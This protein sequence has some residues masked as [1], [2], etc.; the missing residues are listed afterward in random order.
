GPRVGGL[1]WRRGRGSSHQ[2]RNGRRDDSH[3]RR[4]RE[5]LW[6]ML[7]V[8]QSGEVPGGPG[9]SLLI[10]PGTPAPRIVRTIRGFVRPSC[11][12]VR[13]NG[14]PGQHRACPAHLRGDR[15]KR[16]KVGRCETKKVV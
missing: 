4:E 14:E 12:F 16:A 8:R 2:G 7:R 1:V 11:R 5:A 9:E 3:D 10:H 15:T 13:T 6:E